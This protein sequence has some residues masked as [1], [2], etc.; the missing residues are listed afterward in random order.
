MNYKIKFSAN[1]IPE[2]WLIKFGGNGNAVNWLAA[3]VL[4]DLCSPY[5]FLDTN[6]GSMCFMM[7]EASVAGKLSRFSYASVCDRTG[8]EKKQVQRACK[9]LQVMGVIKFHYKTVRLGGVVC[10]NVVF[11]EL[12]PEKISALWDKQESRGDGLSS[13][14]SGWVYVLKLSTEN[15]YKIGM[16][17]RVPDERLADFV[18]K[19]PY[20]ADV[21]AT[22]QTQDPF[23]LET[24][25]H[26][27]YA[28]F[29]ENGEWFR[30]P[31]EVA[32]GLIDY[33]GDYVE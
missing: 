11:S 13:K 33:L 4:A 29:R 17:N 5:F 26:R 16:T 6:S 3:W 22:A 19:M 20:T 30:L 23:A 14:K 10:S 12:V 24:M 15:L 25:R 28:D 2:E 9:L 18:P 21:V 27:H 32:R 31:D 8:Y 1:I 7:D